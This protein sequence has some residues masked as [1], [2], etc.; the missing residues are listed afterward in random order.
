MTSTYC[1][2][3]LFVKLGEEGCVVRVHDEGHGQLK[4]LGPQNRTMMC[5]EPKPVESGQP[6]VAL[7]IRFKIDAGVADVVTDVAVLAVKTSS[8]KT[9]RDGS[10]GSDPIACNP[11]DHDA[12]VVDI[13]VVLLRIGVHLH[14]LETFW[15]GGHGHCS[16]QIHKQKVNMDSSNFQKWL[17]KSQKQFCRLKAKKTFSLRSKSIG[18]K[19]K[20]GLQMKRNSPW[21]W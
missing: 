2:C 14:G 20:Q 10:V 13:I 4:G 15:H 3:Q 17:E 21:N 19:Q 6:L 18:E 9:T 16:L 12:A 8:L 5:N 11:H 1:C 7:G